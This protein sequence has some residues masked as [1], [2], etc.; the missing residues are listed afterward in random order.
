MFLSHIRYE[1]NSS[2][3]LIALEDTV[4]IGQ[5]LIT[6][7]LS[8]LFFDLVC[9]HIFLHFLNKQLSEKQLIK[10]SIYQISPYGINSEL[11]IEF[12]YLLIHPN[13]LCKDIFIEILDPIHNLY[14]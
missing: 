1:I 2:S 11:V 6:L 4:L 12:F 8:N 5:T 7:P 13:I 9:T 10:F 3:D 14:Q